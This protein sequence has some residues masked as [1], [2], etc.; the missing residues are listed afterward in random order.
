VKDPN[1]KEIKFRPFSAER[2]RK[3]FE[4]TDKVIKALEQADKIRPE[5]FHEIV[6]ARA[7]VNTVQDSDVREA[8]DFMDKSL[9]N[10]EDAKKVP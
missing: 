9:A 6:R 10:L 7:G 4:K 8:I 5:I 1:K 3:S 2:L